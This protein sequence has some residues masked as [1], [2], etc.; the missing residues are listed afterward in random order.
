MW[1]STSAINLSQNEEGIDSLVVGSIL[2]L[3]L[4]DLMTMY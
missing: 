2:T 4:S 3:G 1:S